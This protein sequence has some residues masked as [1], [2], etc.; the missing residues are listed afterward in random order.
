MPGVI[1]LACLVAVPL[2]ATVAARQTATPPQPAPPATAF[3][4]GRAIDGSTGK[5]IA[6]ATIVLGTSSAASFAEGIGLPSTAP[7]LSRFPARVLTDSNGSFVFRELPAGTYSLSGTKAGYSSAAYGRSSVSDIASQSIVLRD[8]ERR[9]DM[10]LRF[11]KYGSISGRVLDEAGE[12]LVGL[13]LRVFRRTVTAGRPQYT[14][15]GTT[16]TTD[17][18]GMYRAAT[19]TPGSYVVAIVT[20]QATAPVALID[21]LAAAESGGGGAEFRRELD[22]SGGIGSAIS[23][24][25]RIGSWMLGQ[26]TSEFAGRAALNPRAEKGRVL[27][28]PT[29][30]Y[31]NAS[32]ISS[33]TVIAIDSGEERAAVDLRIKPVPAFSVSGQ[34]SSADTNT[35]FTTITLTAAGVEDSI[36]SGDLT[37]AT[38]STD[39]SGA[40]TF[41][42]VP[43]GDYTMRMV[44]APPRPVSTSSMTTIIQTGTTTISSGGGPTGAAPLGP[45][46]TWWAE[47]SVSVRDRDV[48]GVVLSANRCA[49]RGAVA[50]RWKRRAAA[51]QPSPHDDGHARSR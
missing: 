26:S 3:I 11:W 41:L 42:G 17:D 10:N 45:E 39:A 28:Y 43:S 30:Y 14:V 44:K 46:P 15:A 25:Q 12:P 36:R 40:F 4:L 7:A 22:R 1:R 47:A 24:G 37:S 49:S 38:T 16:A 18:R 50:V 2:F 27:V 31:P 8:A 21:E 32:A 35:G 19:L 29:T 23:G 33:A 20:T 48:S 6:G 13:S 51:G 9:G 34:L 5:P